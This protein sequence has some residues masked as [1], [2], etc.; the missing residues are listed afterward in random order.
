MR[1]GLSLPTLTGY[2]RSTE[3]EGGS[4]RRYEMTYEL[5][6]L[7]ERVGFDFVTI[8]QHRFTLENIDSPQP[9]VT[10][11]A[12]AAQTDRIKLCTN[13]MILPLH[14][15]LEVAEQCAVVDE[16][17]GGRMILGVAIG[18]RP[19]EFAGVGI[20]MKERAPR[21]EEAIAVIR[22]AWQDAPLTFDGK[23]YRTYGPNVSPKPVQKPGIPIWIGA[24]A[25]PA[26]S[27]AARIGD[28]WLTENVESVFSLSPKVARYRLEAKE[29]GRPHDV[30][31]NRRVMIGPDHAYIDEHFLPPVLAAIQNYIKHGL[32]FGDAAFQA[33][34]VSGE[35]IS[36]SEMPEGQLIA[37][38]SAECV[39]AIKLC[40][41]Q[42]D[43]DAIVCDFGRGAWN[44][45]FERFRD[46][47]ER[48]GREV[49]PE[50]A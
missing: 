22:Q 10:L 38:T 30:V 42:T 45:A 24:L 1:F 8:G 48:F 16:I 12:L 36:L 41:T 46:A 44:G 19:Y 23:F 43:P 21:L 40:I 25:D 11:A 49:I 6:Q 37:G 20:E 47:V 13:I 2:A 33:R 39:E 50:F 18:V 28:G 31:L 7:A 35:A 29:H 27:R 3:P 17:S 32:V 9:L 15:P 26:I 34:M 4:R 14:N 5:C